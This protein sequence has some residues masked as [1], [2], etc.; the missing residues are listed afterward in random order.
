MNKIAVN[1]KDSFLGVSSSNLSEIS[2]INVYVNNFIAGSISVAGIILLFML[3]GGGIAMISGAGK[4]DPKSVEQGKKAATSALIGFIVIFF[5][6]WIVRLVETITG[7][8]L[9]S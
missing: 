2:G 1:I 3:I 5:A 6:Y 7:L 4:N 9:I 8:E